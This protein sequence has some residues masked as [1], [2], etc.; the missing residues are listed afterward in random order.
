VISVVVIDDD[1]RVARIHSSFV[2]RVDGFQVVGVAHSGAEAMQVVKGVEPDLILLDL[3]LPDVFGLDL[4]NQL[5]VEGLRSDVIVISA[6]NDSKTVQQ[7][8]QLGVTNYLL[9]PFTLADL[10]Q[11]LEDYRRNWSSRPPYRVGDQSEI[12]RLFGRTGTSL[13]EELP[14]GLS[15][16]TAT[17]I[18]TEVANSSSGLSASECAER[19]GVSRV[20]ARRYLEHYVSRGLMSVSLRYGNA[21]R[22]ERG[23]ALCQRPTNDAVP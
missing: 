1:F 3:Y 23:Y 9:K 2:S 22:P 19:V 17:L 16:E 14:K 4:L 10:H 8:V 7:A 6:G 12:D 20:S 21:G 13:F 15:A 5:R 11:R 18:V